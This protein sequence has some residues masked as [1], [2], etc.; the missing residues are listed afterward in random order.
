MQ[1]ATAGS[2]RSSS[3]LPLPL[4]FLMWQALVVVCLVVPSDSQLFFS[5]AWVLCMPVLAAVC[6]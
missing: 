5:W 2:C 6:D 4:H 3:M 1:K